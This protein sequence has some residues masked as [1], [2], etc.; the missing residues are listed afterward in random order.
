MAENGSQ[1]GSNGRYSQLRELAA[2]GSIALSL[3]TFSK[4]VFFAG[5]DQAKFEEHLRYD[6]ARIDRLEAECAKARE[7]DIQIQSIKD[8]QRRLEET[9]D[10][11]TARLEEDR[12]RGH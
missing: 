12:R 2:L 1:N 3:F 11:A 8:S 9:I 7:I 6:D 4:V 5:S 10:K